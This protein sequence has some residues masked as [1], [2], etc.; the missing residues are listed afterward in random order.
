MWFVAVDSGVLELVCGLWG[1]GTAYGPSPGEK[2]RTAAIG[3]VS[4][5]LQLL[6]CVP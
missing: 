2:G 6:P 3:C 4:V 1:V 5:S